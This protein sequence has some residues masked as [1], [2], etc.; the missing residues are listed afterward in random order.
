MHTAA[1][2][3]PLQWGVFFALILGM[4]ALDLG[5]FNRHAHR[6]GLREAVF[7]SVVWTLVALLFNGWIYRSFGTRAGFEF[8]TGYVIERSLSFDNIFVFVVIFNYFAVPAEQQH[9]V[10]FWGILGALVSRGLFI[11]M[12]TALL[13]RFAWLILVFGAFLVYTGI[14]ILLEKEVEV[15]PERN[16]V[17]KLFRRLI[18][19]SVRYHGKHFF[20]RDGNGRLEATPLMLVLVVVEATDVVF[21]VD[22]IPAV[23][24]VTTNAFLVFTS[25]IFAILGLRALYF[26]LA[27]L[28]HKFRFLSYGLG[29]VLI[30]VGGKMLV[31]DWIDVPIELSLAIVLGILALAITLSLVI[32]VPAEEVPLPDPLAIEGDFEHSPAA[33]ELE[34]EEQAK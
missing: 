20:I 4:L 28:M 26:L 6:V 11:G 19:L 29:A 24:G 22:S 5:V 7:W 12:G 23:F 30:F 16:P 31:H 34:I 10:L 13:A 21:A 9:R 18:P 15:H 14:K 8:L 32:P 1:L 2:G 3:T 25:N 17:L 33:Q 27:G